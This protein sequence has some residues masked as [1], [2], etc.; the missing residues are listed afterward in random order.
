[1]K[2]G[3]EKTFLVLCLLF[4]ALMGVCNRDLWP[5]DELREAEIAREIRDN[6]W[7]PHLNGQPFLEKPPLHYWWMSLSYGL[8]GVSDAAARLPSVAFSLATLG[9]VWLWG[10][11]RLG[12][13]AGAFAAGVLGLS[14]L[15]V[16]NAH[17]VIL[18][19][20]LTFWTTAALFAWDLGRE[21]P[22][23]RAWLLPLGLCAAFWTK[24]PIGVLLPGAALAADLWLERASRP[25]RCFA[26]WESAAFVAAACVLWALILDAEGGDRF[27][28]I[29]WVENLVGR[30][31]SGGGHPEHAGPFYYYLH[32]FPEAFL[33]PAF[34]LPWVLWRM[35]QRGDWNFSGRRYAL[36]ALAQL[37]FLSIPSGKRGLYLLPVLPLASLG[38]GGA[39]ARLIAPDR[40]RV[41]LLSSGALALV[42]GIGLSVLYPHQNEE[43][44]LR[45][46]CD[47]ARALPGIPL[48]YRWSERTQGAVP[49]YLREGVHEAGDFASLCAWLEG[50]RTG[51]VI[52]EKEGANEVMREE[53]RLPVRLI[54]VSRKDWKGVDLALFRVAPERTSGLR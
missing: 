47:E 43:R 29:F 10:E 1:M 19:T 54:L 53:A 3:R 24:G 34:L 37:L 20:S 22:S 51:Y 28:S 26:L 2:Q 50:R 12:S 39:L 41:W 40:R 35:R 33:P 6:P 49:F 23:L 44:S 17:R 30:A 18:D 46:F 5:P 4:L 13:G 31:V 52:A 16:Q 14:G 48:G 15:F 32:R 25:W 38:M 36:W 21:R 11:R 7:I 42:W 45:A 27:L 8:F 9:L